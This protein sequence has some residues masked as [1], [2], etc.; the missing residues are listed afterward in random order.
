MKG[1][2]VL[3][4]F[5]YDDFSQLKVRP[6]VCLTNEIGVYKQIAIAY[7]TSSIP[8]KPESSDVV[9][10]SSLNDFNKTGL[11][12]SST[13]RLHRLA[14]VP[15]QTIINYI[16]NMPEEIMWHINSKLKILFDL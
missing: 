15:S 11:K 10:L 8:N 1:E 6:A 16:G 3:V 7:I 5:P 9:I 2:I 12:T 13:V 4:P 14:S